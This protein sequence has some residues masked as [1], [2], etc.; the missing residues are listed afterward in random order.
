MDTTHIKAPTTHALRYL[1][2]T[3]HIASRDGGTGIG[4]VMVREDLAHFAH[5]AADEGQ[6]LTRPLP[7]GTVWPEILALK[8][9]PTN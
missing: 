2:Y 3:Y 8:S 9:S 4:E 1:T 5:F 6:V 7:A